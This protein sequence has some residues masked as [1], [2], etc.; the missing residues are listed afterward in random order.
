LDVSARTE[1]AKTF[2]KE[3]EAEG[4]HAMLYGNKEWLVTKLDLEELA[5]YDVWLA[6]DGD[7]PDYP[8]EYTMWQYDT[9]GKVSGISGEVSLNV[10]MVDYG[11]D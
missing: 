5:D 3:I 2:L 1:L 4:Y 6:Q 7:T 9:S 11:E 10:G 8:Y